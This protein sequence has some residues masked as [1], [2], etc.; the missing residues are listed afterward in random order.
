MFKHI[1]PWLVLCALVLGVPGLAA[2]EMMT[3]EQARIALAKAK[4]RDERLAR[5]QAYRQRFD[6]KTKTPAAKPKK[7]AVPEL[8]PNAAHGAIALLVGG[9]LVM[10]G[11]RRVRV[12]QR[13]VA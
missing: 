11:R 2:A 9:L 7:P 13:N 8:D 10:A 1:A 4:Q 6:H 5:I 12:V 3:P